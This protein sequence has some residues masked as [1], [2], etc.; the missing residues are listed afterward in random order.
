MLAL[1]VKRFC[2]DGVEVEFHDSAVAKALM[3]TAEGVEEFDAV[4]LQRH[5]D[6]SEEEEK[7][8]GLDLL[9]RSVG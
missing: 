7:A 3:G 6:K 5:R 2:V 8:R 1:G 9:F 4:A